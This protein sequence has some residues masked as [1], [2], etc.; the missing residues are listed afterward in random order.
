MATKVMTWDEAILHVL[1]ENNTAMHYRDIA[2]AIVDQQL[3]PEDKIGST[4]AITVN[5]Y[6]RGEKLKGKVE[7]TGKKGEYALSNKS[8]TANK[9]ISF[10]TSPLEDDSPEDVLITAY[11]R[12][13]DRKQFEVN[14]NELYGTNIQTKKS[15]IVCFSRYSGIYLLHK[16]YEVIYVGQATDL[17]KRI[18]DHTSDD[19][20]NRWDNFS[21]FSITSLKD[22]EMPEDVSKKNLSHKSLLDTLEALLIETLGPER[23]KKVG[24]DFED[25][26]FEQIQEVEYLK[27]KFQAQTATKLAK[28]PQKTSSNR[29]EVASAVAPA[30]TGPVVVARAQ[31][32]TIPGVTTSSGAVAERPATSQK[33]HGRR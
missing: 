1:R 11:G 25:K 29:P 13:W 8:Q 12:F 4:P 6:L 17:A 19:K 24:N 27:R 28:Q 16:G 7:P 23:N 15:A 5:S 2:S 20:R 3:R 10:V 26:E 9:V 22:N 31:V 21:W 18:A 32:T 14:N 30:G 33:R